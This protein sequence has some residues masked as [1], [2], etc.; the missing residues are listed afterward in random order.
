MS[1][2]KTMQVKGSS[3]LAVPA[4]VQARF[5]DRYEEWIESLSPEAKHI[6]TRIILA[7]DLYPLYPAMVE[8]T[9]KVCEVFYNGSEHGAWESGKFSADYALNGIL[10]FLYRVGSPHFIIDRAARVFSSYYP[11]GEV[12]VVDTSDK[13]VVLQVVKFPE[14]YAILDHDMG[15]WI[16]GTLELLKCENPIVK[17]VSSLSAGD[18]VTEF[19]ATWS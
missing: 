4:F 6:H 16:E 18:S 5:P 8:P 7:S 17:I 13:K 3:I 2:E 1:T 15:G 19:L 12:K 11:E 10:K 9:Q 14:P